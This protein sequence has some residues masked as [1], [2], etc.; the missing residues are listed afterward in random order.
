MMVGGSGGIIRNSRLFLTSS[1]DGCERSASAAFCFTPGNPLNRK[2][3][4]LRSGLQVLVMTLPDGVEIKFVYCDLRR[5]LF[6]RYSVR[7][8]KTVVKIGGMVP[9]TQMYCV[10]VL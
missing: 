10:C 4:G 2:L 5:A 1:L 7:C 8:A 6:P 9:L 3:G